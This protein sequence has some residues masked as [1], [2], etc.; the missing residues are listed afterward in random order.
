MSVR[1][2]AVHLA[3]RAALSLSRTHQAC[4]VAGAA[5]WHAECADRCERCLVRCV[6]CGC[7]PTETDHVCSIEIY[8]MCS[9]ASISPLSVTSCNLF[10]CYLGLLRGYFTSMRRYMDASLHGYIDASTHGLWSKRCVPC[11]YR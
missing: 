9:S 10:G 5:V 11:T 2:R 4:D 3:A 7:A 1:A 8:R 6:A